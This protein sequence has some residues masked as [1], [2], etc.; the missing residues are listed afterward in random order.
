MLWAMPSGLSTV[1][2]LWYSM[3]LRIFEAALLRVPLMP[4]STVERLGSDYGGWDVP[5]DVIADDWTV[6]S[7]GAGHD[8]S[9]DAAVLSRT[10]A[11]VRSFDIMHRHLSDALDQTERSPRFSVHLVA[12]GPQD[13]PVRLFGSPD[14]ATGGATSAHHD[15]EGD[16]FELPGRSIPSLAAELGDSRIDLLKIDVEG[17]EYE[18]LDALD[19]HAL[20]VQ[21]LGVDFH[22]TVSP[23]A[24]RR[25]IEHVR[26]QGFDLISRRGGDLV[27]LRRALVHA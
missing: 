15:P 4:M 24:A 6:Y 9:F 21:M 22:P 3:K 5:V 10:G 18:L 8:V 2:S 20:G 14:Q 13:A 12:I 16:W 23:R 26:R 25:R 7:I 17:G 11:Q 27:F 1:G 19:L